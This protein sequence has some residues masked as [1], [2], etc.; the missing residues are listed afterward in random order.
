MVPLRE[1]VLKYRIPHLPSFGPVY[2]VLRRCRYVINAPTHPRDTLFSMSIE[3]ARRRS[4]PLS[5]EKPVFSALVTS[6][7][8]RPF[9]GTRKSAVS[10]LSG[11]VCKA[12]NLDAAALALNS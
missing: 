12:A 11:E 7:C 10:E 4:L 6:C 9:P 2:S 8:V 3:P 5:K 1:K